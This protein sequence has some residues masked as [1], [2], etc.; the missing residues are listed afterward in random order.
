M[1][2][3]FIPYKSAVPS[4]GCFIK[5][6]ET[7]VCERF[8]KLR[9]PFTCIVAGAT[10][11]GK[12]EFV[13]RLLKHRDAVLHPPPGRVIYSYERYQPKFDGISGVEFVK[14]SDY[15][16]R[17]GDN[18]LLI[19][20]DQMGGKA[21]DLEKLFTVDSHHLGVSVIFIT[22]NLFEQSKAYR[23]VALNA[24]YLFLFKSP[25]AAQQVTI[26]ARQLY[27]SGKSVRAFADAYTHATRNP[28]SYLLVD[29]KPDTPERLRVRA[30]VLPDEGLP[31]AGD[32]RLSHCYAV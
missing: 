18:T 4:R 17:R 30:N 8:T 25:R 24:Q 32:A 6:V 5:M 21:S 29:L 11:S 16:L 14:G 28:F 23:T 22:Q 7:K 12:T 13:L 20:D 9:T 26:L 2:L 3:L 15:A 1:L 10:G 27:P 31:F 19:I